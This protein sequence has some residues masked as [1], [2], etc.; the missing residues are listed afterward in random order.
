MTLETERLILRPITKEDA[1]DIYEYSRSPV[2]GPNA[3]WKP[4]ANKKETLMIIEEIFLEQENVFGIVLK[5]TGKMIGSVGLISDPKREYG[6]AKMLGYAIGDLYWGNGYTTEASLA[7]IDYGFQERY[8]HLITAY[9]YPENDRSKRVIAKCGFEYE[10]T[11]K[12]AEKLFNG[13]VKD[14]Q[15]FALFA[16]KY[17]NDSLVENNK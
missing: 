3:G 9:C 14:H 6:S 1:D 13:E 16:E 12:C 17:E 7:V 8:C 15:C 5:E 11:L 2:V 4:H 10:G